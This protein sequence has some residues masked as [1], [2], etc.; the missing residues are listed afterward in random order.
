M[1]YRKNKTYFEVFSAG[2]MV[3]CIIA[4]RFWKEHAKQKNSPQDPIAVGDRVRFTETTSGGQIT[5]LLPRATKFSRKAPPS[6]PGAYAGEQIIA[7]NVDQ[8]VPVF[9]AANPP[10]SW[11]MLDRYLVT[12]EASELPALVCITKVDLAEPGIED[13]AAA[14]RAIGYRVILVS[15]V[16][17]EGVGEMREALRGR[18]S[19]LLG[20]SG[21]GKTTLLNAL[22][23]GLGLRTA[24]I[25]QATG[26][27]KHTTSASEMF[28]LAFGGAVLDTPGVRTFGLWEIGEEDLAWYFPEMRPYLERC[29]FGTSCRHD[30]EPGCAVRKAV[31]SGLI[32]PRRYQSYMR[33]LQSD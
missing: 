20:K 25:S 12:A 17:G 23:P 27:G 7:A 6:M 31:V 22:E 15:S 8:V 4:S 9:A 2:R 28:P 19:V 18:I 3:T 11:N 10:P 33:M 14:Y 29:R 5:E 32:E 13:I 1:V 16:T 24:A 26:K 30:Q 21:A